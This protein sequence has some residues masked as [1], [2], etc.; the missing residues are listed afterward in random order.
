M[1]SPAILMVGIWSKIQDAFEKFESLEEKEE[2]ESP[3]VTGSSP[4]ISVMHTCPS[5]GDVEQR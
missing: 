5:T 2:K 3:E 4:S 1:L